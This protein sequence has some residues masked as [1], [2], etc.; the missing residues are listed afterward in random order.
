MTKKTSS[1]A[2]ESSSENGLRKIPEDLQRLSDL[3]KQVHA[4]LQR[5]QVLWLKAQSPDQQRRVVTDYLITLM[6]LVQPYGNS[7]LT[8]PMLQLISALENL[9]DG[10]RP[11]LLRPGKPPKGG[12]PARSL[13]VVKMATA[14]AL[15]T[16]LHETRKPV[17]EGELHIAA[18]M[19]IS[20]GALRSWRKQL[21][22]KR[23]GQVASKLYER[24]LNTCREHG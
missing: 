18:H 4:D 6:Q 11:P 12:R 23:K 16:L 10:L 3:Y 9:E 15:V 22:S 1:D 17:A 14:S 7:I 21:M 24:V 2:S 13:N 8:L 20:V 5:N 19:K